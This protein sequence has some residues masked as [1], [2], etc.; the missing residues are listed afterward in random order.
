MIVRK[1]KLGVLIEVVRLVKTLQ[2]EVSELQKKEKKRNL[3]AK[4]EKERSEKCKRLKILIPQPSLQQ[5][6]FYA[7]LHNNGCS[8]AITNSNGT[9]VDVNA[10]FC[11]AVGSELV[12]VLGCSFFSFAH[13]SSLPSLFS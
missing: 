2:V 11:E 7:F 5:Q 1:N 6:Q 4:K 10:S 13:P 3:Q 8:W 12:N 9:I